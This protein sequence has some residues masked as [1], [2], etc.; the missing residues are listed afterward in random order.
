MGL[1]KVKVTYWDEN[2]NKNVI[3]TESITEKSSN[4]HKLLHGKF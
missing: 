1:Y 2:D 4:G 3:Y